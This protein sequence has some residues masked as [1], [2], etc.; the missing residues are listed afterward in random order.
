[1]ETETRRC[2]ADFRSGRVG[3][4][5]NLCRR[6]EPLMQSSERSFLQTHPDFDAAEVRQEITLAVYAAAQSYDL[7]AQ[8]VTFGLYAR[9]CIR[10]RP[11]WLARHTARSCDRLTDSVTEDIPSAEPDPEQC[12][13]D[14]ESYR[15]LVERIR[16]E[17]TGLESRVLTLSLEGFTRSEISVALR[18]TQKQVDNA[19]YRIRKKVK[20]LL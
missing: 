2:L 16:S 13:M 18:L 6:Y 7:S 3:A 14:A 17:L 10:N 1:M 4:F 19:R 20:R 8:D 11:Y 5:D 9:V 15:D 12:A